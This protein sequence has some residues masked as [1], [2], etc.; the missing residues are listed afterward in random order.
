PYCLPPVKLFRWRI[1]LLPRGGEIPPP[2]SAGLGVNV[3]PHD[4]IDVFDPTATPI[5]WANK[6]F[7]VFALPGK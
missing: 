7:D 1:I 3:K 2:L 6:A 4:S 5:S